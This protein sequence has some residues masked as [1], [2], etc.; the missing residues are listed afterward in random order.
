MLDEVADSAMLLAD[1]PATPMVRAPYKLILLFLWGGVG[2]RPCPLSVWRRFSAPRFK[3]QV[4]V[5]DRGDVAQ[6]HFHVSDDQLRS[7]TG[8]VDLGDGA[9]ADHGVGDGVAA[10]I[11]GGHGQ[12]VR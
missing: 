10:R 9:D 8:H 7:R 1:R 11:R 2:V 12:L 6:S 4:S 3:I 5:C